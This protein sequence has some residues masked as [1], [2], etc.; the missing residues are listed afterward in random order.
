MII[1]DDRTE[2]QKK[3]HNVLIVGTDKFLSGWGQAEGGASYAAW[4]CRPEDKYQVERWVRNRGD[5]LRV[6]EV[7]SNY[8]PNSRYCVHFHIYVV[9]DNHS[10]IK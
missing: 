4:A 10:A 1:V 7:G 2:E 3:T 9:D 5:M 6:R 8:R